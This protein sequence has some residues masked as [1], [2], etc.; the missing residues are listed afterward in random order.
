M[1]TLRLLILVSS[2]AL[3]STAVAQSVLL[4]DLGGPHGFGVSD[5]PHSDDDGAGP[6]SLADASDTQAK[7][8]PPIPI[9]CRRKDQAELRKKFSFK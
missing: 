9:L 3:G 6:I 1:T 7:P 5:L 8:P 4:N 2:L